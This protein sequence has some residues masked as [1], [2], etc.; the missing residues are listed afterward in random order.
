VS[1]R[2]E[3]TDE[4][5]RELL[6]AFPNLQAMLDGCVSGHHT[7]W[8]MMRDELR[9]LL[10]TLSGRAEPGEPVAWIEHHKGGDNLCWDNPGRKCSP[11]YTAPPTRAAIPDPL[12]EA[13]NSGD[14]VYRP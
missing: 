12:G 4:R 2:H 3:L 11:L 14:G 5:I 13:L 6:S 1:H 7:E 8:P 9:R 10:Q